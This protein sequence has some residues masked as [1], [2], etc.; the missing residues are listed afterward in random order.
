MVDILSAPP[1]RHL[2][3]NL[4]GDLPVSDVLSEQVLAYLRDPAAVLQ[5]VRVSVSCLRPRSA[6]GRSAWSLL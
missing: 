6:R 2:R 3:F 5:K 1:V 4:E